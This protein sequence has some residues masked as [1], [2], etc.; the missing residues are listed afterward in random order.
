ML[1]IIIDKPGVDPK[2]ARTMSSH[3]IT[4]IFYDRVPYKGYYYIKQ[5]NLNHE[6]ENNYGRKQNNYTNRTT[7]T[8]A[9]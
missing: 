3:S 7:T 5:K 8:L 9:G 2:R 6:D 4:T 1:G